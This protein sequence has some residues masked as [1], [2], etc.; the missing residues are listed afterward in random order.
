MKKIMI[1]LFLCTIAMNAQEKRFE[2]I[3]AYKTA[4][5]T[6]ALSLTASEAEKFWPIYNAHEEQMMQLR[7]KEREEVFNKLKDGGVDN[8]TDA[9][10]NSLIEKHQSIKAEGL[11]NEANLHKALRGVISPQKIIKLQKAEEDF[12]RNLLRRFNKRGNRGEKDDRRE[13]PRR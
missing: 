11:K 1:V 10:A 5:I 12:K 4:H 2:K 9:E 3:K 13:F 6:E 8:L 7:K